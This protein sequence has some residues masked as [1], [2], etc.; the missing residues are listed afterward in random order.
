MS[1]AAMA[2]KM[3]PGTPAETPAP[4]SSLR[5]GTFMP[6]WPP[7]SA[8]L[9]DVGPEVDEAVPPVVRLDARAGDDEEATDLPFGEGDPFGLGQ[10]R[11][12]QSAVLP[13]TGLGV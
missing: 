13:R 2:Q 7:S 4:P 12:A 10:Q 1:P 6:G 9:S 11:G 3:Q 8:V 5:R